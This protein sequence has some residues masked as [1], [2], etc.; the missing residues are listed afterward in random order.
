[1]YGEESEA[2]PLDH[3]N[4]YHYNLQIKQGFCF[5]ANRTEYDTPLISII[6]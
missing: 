1:M 5:L 3:D 6:D 2:D 4:K